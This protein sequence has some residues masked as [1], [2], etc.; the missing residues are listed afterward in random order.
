M[1]YMK[2]CKDKSF[3]LAIVD[4]NYGI[5]QDGR[6]NHSRGLLARSK[7]YRNNFKYDDESPDENYFAELFR[8]SKE[9]IVFG[10]N[11]FISKIPLDSSCWVVWDKMNGLTDFADCELAWTSFKSSVRIFRFRWQGMLQGNMKSKQ[12]RIHPN[13]KP[14]ELYKWLLTKYAKAGD[15]ILDTHLGSGSIAIACHDYGFDLTGTEIDV[16]YYNAMLKR[17]N[18]HKSQTKLFEVS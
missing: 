18:N 11:H 1:E 9:Q 3:D 4:V 8:V 2:G 7:D 12:R 10:A 14:I 6:Q 16:D 17:F 5:Q 13:E 15:K